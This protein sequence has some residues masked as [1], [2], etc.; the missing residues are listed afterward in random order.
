[1]ND[2]LT[3]KH[4]STTFR[5][6]QGDVKAVCDVNLSIKPGEV[7]GLVG[8]TGCGKSVLGQSLLR[9]LPHSAE[10]LGEILFE[11]QDLNALTDGEIRAIRGRRLAYINQNPTEALNPVLKVSTQLIESIRICESISRREARAKAE[12]ILASLSFEHPKE[13]MNK[14]PNELSGGMKQ[15]VLTAMALSG[16]PP[17]LIADE[18]TKGLD[19]LIRGQVIDSLQRF[20]TLT[21]CGGLIITH[22]LKFARAVCHSLALM[23]AGEIV[24]HG[25]TEAL[26]TNPQHPYLK[27]L[28]SAMPENG[29]RAL[30]GA[31]CSLIDLPE[32][33]RFCDRCPRATEA[34]KNVH[35]PLK[36]REDGREVRCLLYD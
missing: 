26:M 8:E 3:C 33:C 28:I 12:E 11:G 2:I 19:A 16:K 10:T 9:L 4:V 15:R 1:M 6:R 35:P 31:A 30:P 7:L 21:G 20:I 14:Y 18:P 34:C 5:G 32:G 27:A 25:P 23:Y 13:I 24:E 29:M 36:A 17:F 22:D